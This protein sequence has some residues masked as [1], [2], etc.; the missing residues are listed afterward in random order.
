MTKEE[1][2]NLGR[3]YGFFTYIDSNRLF[4]KPQYMWERKRNTPE[5]TLIAKY[6]KP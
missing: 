1:F 3:A 6:L 2:D 4:L 5:V